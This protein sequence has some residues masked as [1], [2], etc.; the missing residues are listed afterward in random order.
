MP[1]LLDSQVVSEFFSGSGPQSFPVLTAVPA[2]A[3]LSVLVIDPFGYGG[4]PS[5]ITDSQGN[6]YNI[7]VNQVGIYGSGNLFIADSILATGLTT[8]DTVSLGWSGTINNMSI[9]ASSF[10]GVVGF[11]DTAYDGGFGGTRT[12]I[13]TSTPGDLVIGYAGWIDTPVT[14]HGAPFS[15]MFDVSLGS[16]GSHPFHDNDI[17]EWAIASAGATTTYSASGTNYG[18]LAALSYVPATSQTVDATSIGSSE[19]FGTPFISTGVIEPTGIPSTEAFGLP[20][21]TPHNIIPS[22]IPPAEA[23]GTPRIEQ[24][25]LRPGGIPSSEAFGTPRL[26]T[27]APQYIVSPGILSGQ[28]F[29]LPSLAVGGSAGVRPVGAV[30]SETFGTPIIFERALGVPPRNYLI[31]R[32]TG[33]IYP[34]PLNHSTEDSVKSLGRRVTRS[35]I[36]ASGKLLTTRR[37]F[38]IRHPSV[39]GPVHLLL[40]GT[41]LDRTP[42][43]QYETFVRFWREGTDRTFDFID[44]SGDSYHIA[45]VSVDARRMPSVA[46]TDGSYFQYSLEVE[47]IDVNEGAYKGYA[48]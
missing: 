10:S 45:I 31:D 4:Q 5:T 34:W 33:E 41:M 25:A 3:M 11:R 23:F 14:P 9:V 6:A 35:G 16:I 19:G 37:V 17:G 13:V 36:T 18:V 21:I 28:V 24:P 12:A 42:P 22:S 20:E 30:T 38:L 2:G 43:T 32:A 1:A 27:Y 29:G 15:L 47:V 26:R 39:P 7:R 8:S 46:H 44:A 40:H 48:V